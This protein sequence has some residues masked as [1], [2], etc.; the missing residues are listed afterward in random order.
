MAHFS[1]WTDEMLRQIIDRARGSRQ[2][3][4]SMRAHCDRMQRTIL[5]QQQRLREVA[6]RLASRTPR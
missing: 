6:S 3:A 1:Q 4:Q 2:R 5:T